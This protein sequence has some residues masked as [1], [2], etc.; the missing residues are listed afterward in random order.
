MANEYTLSNTAVNIDSAISRVVGAD[1]EPKPNSQ[2]MVTSG[3][4]YTAISDL[5]SFDLSVETSSDTVTDTDTALATSAAIIDLVDSKVPKTTFVQFTGTITGN[6]SGEA[7]YFTPTILS[8]NDNA[9]LLRASVAN[10]PSPNAPQSNSNKPV[11][12]VRNLVSLVAG[13]YSFEFLPYTQLLDFMRLVRGRQRNVFEFGANPGGSNAASVTLATGHSLPGETP[14]FYPERL[15][16]N[17][18]DITSVYLFA[19]PYT[20]NS[21]LTLPSVILRLTRTSS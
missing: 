21:T 13:D 4:V 3:A 8:T 17:F 12:L 14:T 9:N 20:G 19:N 16:G 7:G 6:V 5:S 18:N 1:N 11:S 15:S 2:N 10:Y